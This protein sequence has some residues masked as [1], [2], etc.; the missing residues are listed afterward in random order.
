MRSEDTSVLEGQLEEVKVTD[1]T[2]IGKKYRDILAMGDKPGE[3]RDGDKIERRSS[4]D[5]IPQFLRFSV[6]ISP[7]SVVSSVSQSNDVHLSVS[8]PSIHYTHSVNLVREVEMFVSEFQQLSRAVMESFSSAAVG[9]AKGIVNEKS[10]FAEQLSTSLGPRAIHS[11]MF[12]SVGVPPEIETTDAPLDSAPRDHLYLDIL[13]QS[14][15]ITLPSSLHGDKCLVAYLGEISVKNSF[16]SGGIT[17]SLSKSIA[18]NLQPEREILT[19]KIDRMSLHATQDVRSRE[20][21]VASGGRS[22]QGKWWKVLDETSVVVKID[23][24]VGGR[25]GEGEKIDSAGAGGSTENIANGEGTDFDIKSELWTIG[26]TSDDRDGGGKGERQTPSVWVSETD[27]SVPADVV[28]T[29]EI[30]DHLL[31]SLPKE[32]FDQIRV[33]LKHG[34]YKPTSQKR[35][36]QTEEGEAS[37]SNHQAKRSNSVTSSQS[38]QG[39]PKSEQSVKATSDSPQTVAVNFSLPRLSLQLKHTIGSK[40]KDLVFISFEEFTANCHKSEPHTTSVEIALKSIIIEDLIQ[41]KES[42]YRYILASSTKPFT[43]ISPM[44]SAASSF[45]LQRL[46]ISPSHLSHPLLP[47]SHLMSSTPRVAPSL[48]SASPLRSFT[49]HNFRGETGKTSL[50]PDPTGSVREQSTQLSRSETSFATPKTSLRHPSRIASSSQEVKISVSEPSFPDDS[51]ECEMT[52]STLR[53]EGSS[54]GSSLRGNTSGD[55]MGL[56]SIKAVSI[57]KEHPHFTKRFNSVS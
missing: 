41:D 33:T 40:E 53:P 35:K 34:L 20:L 18:G 8:V 22:S 7:Q 1:L 26:E 54:H 31:I 51:D 2:E 32:V 43:G 42:E 4:E 49:P 55:V 27:P 3:K 56:L 52:G 25:V 15:V 13:V 12:H 48:D 38:S 37:L 50:R 46:S 14:P 9:V 21:L 24:K 57:D 5:E 6:H 45:G 44:R 39:V 16:G 28:V 29:G 17:D 47:F 19:V 30:C 23:R 11:S 36:T 10:Q